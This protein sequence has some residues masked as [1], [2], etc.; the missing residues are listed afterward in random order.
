MKALSIFGPPGCGKTHKLIQIIGEIRERGL[1]ENEIAFLTFTRAAAAEAANRLGFQRSDRFGTMHSMCY[2]TLG[3]SPQSIINF[4]K[5][6]EFA[7][8]V[9]VPITGKPPDEDEE[10]QDGDYMLDIISFAR[11]LMIDPMQAYDSS[12]RPASP[13]V[14]NMFEQAYREWKSAHGYSDFTDMLEKVLHKGGKISYPVRAIIIDEAQDL[15]PL[16]WAVIDRLIKD[17]PTVE[18]ACIAGDDDQCIYVWGGAQRDGM[19][20]FEKKYNARREVLTQ[21]YRIPAAVHTLSQELITQVGARVD[22]QFLPRGEE[23]AVNVYGDFDLLKFD[24]DENCLLIARTHS[25]LSEIEKVLQQDRVPYLKDSGRPGLL[26]NR[27]GIAIRAWRR[28]EEGQEVTADQM[29]H[30]MACLSVDD[31][32]RVRGG[33]FAEIKKRGW[34]TSIM[35]PPSISEYYDHVD[36][37]ASPN[38]RLSTI[39]SVKGREADRV[40]LI[41]DVTG[42]ISASIE[43]NPDDEIRVF[44]VGVTR[45]KHRLDIV[46]GDSPVPFL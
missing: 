16:Q 5:L 34:R 4:R 9:G 1:K 7:Q 24:K 40:V 37:D 2:R 44:Y 39:H 45:A 27:F 15:S 30:L 22:K 28:M 20:E 29:K 41:N 43:Q 8:K 26:Q 19:V 23:G 35:I 18:F 31:A 33:R 38:L 36:I 14:F 17:N 11:S 6:Q 13:E 32:A 46:T 25:K 21:S 10:R 3:L 42:R 12:D